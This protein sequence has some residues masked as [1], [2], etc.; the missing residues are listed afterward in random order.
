[1]RIILLGKPGAG[2]GTQARFIMEHFGIPQVSTGD[3]LRA[4]VKSGSALGLAARRFM[5]AGDLVPDDVVIG[6]VKER[7]SQPDCA[8]GFLFDG[9]PRTV[10]Q[11][12]AM[13]DADVR[14]DQVLEVDISDEEVRTRLTGR[15]SHP[16]S[17]RVYHVVF[18]PPKVAGQDDVTGEPL[19]HRADDTEETV[20]NRLAVYHRDTA[21]I[22]RFYTAWASEDAARAP[23]VT[24]VAGTGTVDEIRAR[25]FAALAR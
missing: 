22:V 2:K 3:M 8:R 12:Q 16:A 19:A 14:L 15:R 25:V 20:N 13:R 5:D 6:L 24:K 17:G 18:N 9:F 10:P 23:R 4:A 11:A 21:P 7:L 1:M